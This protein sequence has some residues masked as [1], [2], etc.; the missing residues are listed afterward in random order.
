MIDQIENWLAEEYDKVIS[1][2]DSILCDYF[3]DLEENISEEELKSND[4]YNKI[5]IIL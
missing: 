3:S 5:I 2:I 1:N 4:G